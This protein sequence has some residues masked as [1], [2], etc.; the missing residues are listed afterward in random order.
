MLRQIVPPVTD[1]GDDLVH[2]VSGAE[3]V[4]EFSYEV[5]V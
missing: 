3:N 1:D 5:H 4:S 2:V